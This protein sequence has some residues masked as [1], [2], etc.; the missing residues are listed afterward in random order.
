[1]TIREFLADRLG[2]LLLGPVAMAAAAVFLRFTGTQCGVLV[3]LLIAWCLLF[4]AVQTVDYYKCCAHLE[5][6]ETIMD[7]LD[8]KHLFAE[9]VPKPQGIYERRLFALMRRSGKAMIESVSAARSSQAEYR[10]Y[11]ESWVHEIKTPITAAQLL[12]RS[13][14]PKLR[15][16][17]SRELAQIDN[18]VERTLFYARTESPEKDF[19]IRQVSLAEIVAGAIERHRMLLIQNGVSI[20]TEDLYYHVYTDHKWVSFMLGQLLQ[21]AV[22]YRNETPVITISTRH[23]GRQVQLILHD[24]GMGIP[25]H[26]LPRIF[27]RGFTGSNGRSRVGATGIGLYLCQRLSGFLE[28]NLHV[29]SQE[30]QGTSVILTFPAKET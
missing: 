10:D 28:I 20:N 19:I 12:C 7:G 4:I 3:I 21:N 16:Q 22:R 14:E 15:R 29:K 27:E 2:R 8:Q 9:C 5:E 30:G 25:P 18:H 11:I 17:L 1:M 24:N 13:A 23:L 6:L 26:E